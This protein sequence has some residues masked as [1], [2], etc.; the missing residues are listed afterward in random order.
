MEDI[1][2][3]KEVSTFLNQNFLSNRFNTENFFNQIKASNW[4]VK[5][6]PS[7]VFFTPEGK[8]LM[9][10]QGKK[11]KEEV[12]SMAMDAL[13]K[14]KE[15]EEKK[16]KKQNRM[17]DKEHLHDEIE[18]DTPAPAAPEPS[19]GV[20]QP[21]VIANPVMQQEITPVKTNESAPVPMPGT[22]SAVPVN[23]QEIVIPSTEG[24]SL[25]EQQTTPDQTLK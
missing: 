16:Y 5:G 1:F 9:L 7:Y 25:P 11:S 19:A 17:T 2:N 13:G 8:M 6:F 12:I 18:Q 10:Q 14:F 4:G 20:A 15:Y 21:Q 3:N 23:Q 24:I 22:E